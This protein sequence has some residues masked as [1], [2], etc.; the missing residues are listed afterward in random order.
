MGFY[1]GA[2]GAMDE[3]LALIKDDTKRQTLINKRAVIAG[4]RET[5]QLEQDRRLATASKDEKAAIMT[6]KR[7]EAKSTQNFIHLIS[8]DIFFMITDLLLGDNPSIACRL[9]AVCTEWRDVL[10]DRPYVWSNLVLGRTRPVLKAE[11]FVERNQGNLRKLTLIPSFKAEYEQKVSEIIEPHINRLEYFGFAVKPNTLIANLRG[12]FDSIQEISQS[13]RDSSVKRISDPEASVCRP[14]RG[15]GLIKPTLQRLTVEDSCF[16]LGGDIYRPGGG[17]RLENC[18]RRGYDYLAKLK[19]LTCRNASILYD[20]DFLETLHRNAPLLEEL[21]MHRCDPV[22]GFQL[23]SDNS[24]YNNDNNDES[25]KV[26]DHLTSVIGTSNSARFIRFDT[27]HVPN[28]VRLELSKSVVSDPKDSSRTI[29]YGPSVIPQLQGVGLADALPNLQVLDVSGNVAASETDALLNILAGLSSLRFLNVS[30]TPYGDDILHALT[31]RG[32]RD[33]QEHEGKPDLLPELVGLSVC[34]LELSS[35]ALRDFVMS[36][37][38]KSKQEVPVIPIIQSKTS[39]AFRPSGSTSRSGS[40]L[41]ASGPSSERQSS[42][43]SAG[44]IS[45]QSGSQHPR[46]MRRAG[47]KWLCL[48]HV[49]TVDTQLSVYLATKL[50]F[51][52]HSLRNKMNEERM[53]GKG[54]YSWD[55]DRYHSC[56]DR[57]ENMCTVQRVI[58][59]S[60][61]MSWRNP[62]G[63][64]GC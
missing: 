43:Q 40:Q 20:E 51:V 29:S 24:A 31:W 7:K 25:K 23:Y 41:K 49:T 21:E 38:P 63:L 52:S 11:K 61:W 30:C 2:L 50:P 14:D 35:L 57:S 44:V 5:A 26:L 8:D 15:M 6:Q 62:F 42:T 55:L 32:Q 22:P 46:S 47:F 53:K 39:S 10:Y 16:G 59:T 64:I 13:A 48:D 37:L 19:S 45:S 18:I 3:A 12:R 27:I 28:L 60:D 4:E 9:S 56:T 1:K 33:L 36:R 17:I 34:G 54:R 58:G